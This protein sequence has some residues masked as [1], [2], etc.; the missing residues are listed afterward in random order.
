MQHYAENN[1]LK[2]QNHTLLCENK[3]IIA[4]QI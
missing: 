2:I 4:K 3:K 1:N